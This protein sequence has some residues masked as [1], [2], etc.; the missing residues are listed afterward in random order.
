[1]WKEVCRIRTCLQH[2]PMYRFVI[3][4]SKLRTIRA[5]FNC[6]LY[7]QVFVISIYYVFTRS[8]CVKHISFELL[9]QLFHSQNVHDTCFFL[10]LQSVKSCFRNERPTSTHRTYFLHKNYKHHVTLHCTF[11]GSAIFSEAQ[12]YVIG[13]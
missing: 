5:N 9:F 12:K 8:K 10:T 4:K 13:I 6:N 1:M 7:R 11:R 2:T 3:F